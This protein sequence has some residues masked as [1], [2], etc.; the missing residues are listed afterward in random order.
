MFR[1]TRLALSALC[2][3]GGAQAATVHVED[4][5]RIPSISNY[6]YYTVDPILLDIDRDGT[7]DVW[8]RA[9]SSSSSR[10]TS[11]G[12]LVRGENGTR[13]DTGAMRH[14]G[15]AINASL[16]F[17][18]YAYP[19]T[20]SYRR[21]RWGSSSR[22]YSG[23]WGD[24]TSASRQGFMGVLLSSGSFGWLELAI[25]GNGFGDL[26]AWG[27]ETESG[28]PIAAGAVQTFVASEAAPTVPLPAS[29]MLLAGAVGGLVLRTRR[30]RKTCAATQ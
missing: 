6:S 14:A 18:D 2:L 22:R 15:D 8:L 7:D 27:Y 25:N 26:V 3:A 24:G 23:T 19:T 4:G 20:Y 5:R 17:A 10:S 28:V 11:T 13:I 16:T 9:Y 30:A 12:L 29:G 21:S 1:T